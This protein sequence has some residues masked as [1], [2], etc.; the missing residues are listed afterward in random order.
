MA[1]GMEQ[2]AHGSGQGAKLLE[3]REHLD[4][5][6]RHGVW[7][8]GWCCLEPGVGPFHLG[9]FCDCMFNR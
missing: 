5:A 3:F 2:A 1:V 6:L 8:W 4:N 7:I 9:I